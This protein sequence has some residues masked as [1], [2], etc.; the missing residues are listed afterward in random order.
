M[1]NYSQVMFYSHTL[2]CIRSKPRFGDNIAEWET[3]KQVL[4]GWLFLTGNTKLGKGFSAQ[5]GL[6]YLLHSFMIR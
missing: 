1:L 3:Y 6:I 4:R 2:R 5:R